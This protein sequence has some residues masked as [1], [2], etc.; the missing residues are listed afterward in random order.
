[1]LCAACSE[2]E[3]KDN[4]WIT[5]AK[6]KANTFAQVFNDKAQLPPELI[7]CPFFGM[8]DDE[9]EKHI[10]F[11]S[12]TCRR[13]LKKLDEKKAS[14]HDKISAVIL[15][16][17]SDCLCIPFAYIC[18]RIFEEGCWPTM[19]KFHLIVP[20]YKRGAAFIPGN[21]RG[22]HL[23]TILSKI[24]EKMIA[25]HLVP[26]LQKR[27]FFNGHFQEGSVRGTWSRC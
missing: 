9:F 21:Y 22:V 17:L 12:R 6:E 20:I 27:A 18:R 14:G 4:N 15:K 7:D 8:P 10:C 26:F 2:K 24:A 16:K 11:R 3:K 5:D 1:M 13:L 25:L 19:W 23:T